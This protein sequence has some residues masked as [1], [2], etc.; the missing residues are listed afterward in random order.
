MIQS[1]ATVTRL[2]VISSMSSVALIGCEPDI[3]NTDT[4]ENAVLSGSVGG[5]DPG[6]NTIAF[7]NVRV[8]FLAVN[9]D[10]ISGPSSDSFQDLNLIEGAELSG[11]CA[12]DDDCED[13]FSCALPGADIKEDTLPGTCYQPKLTQIEELECG[14]YDVQLVAEGGG[15]CSFELKAPDNDEERQEGPFLDYQGEGRYLCFTEGR[16]VFDSSWINKDT[17]PALF[18]DNREAL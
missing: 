17:C 6:V 8:R 15:E 10:E 3:I 2:A 18:P 4:I 16:W 12:E 9:E 13:G 7:T 5:D 14:I 11:P 1:F